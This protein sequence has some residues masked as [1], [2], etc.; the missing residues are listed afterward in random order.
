[1]KSVPTHLSLSRLYAAI[2]SIVWVGIL[3]MAW[4][5]IKPRLGPLMSVGVSW[6]FPLGLIYYF[7]VYVL[8]VSIIMWAGLG[9]FSLFVFRGVTVRRGIWVVPVAVVMTLSVWG[10]VVPHRANPGVMA[11]FIFWLPLAPAFLISVWGYFSN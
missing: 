2:F 10:L 4:I 7:A 3:S 8:I 11:S 6:P 9:L 5:E 1:M